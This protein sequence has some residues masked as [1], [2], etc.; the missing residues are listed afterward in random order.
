MIDSFLDGIT[1]AAFFGRLRR[2]G[3]PTAFADF[4]SER[5]SEVSNPL[6]TKTTLI[7]RRDTLVASNLRAQRLGQ[8]LARGSAAVLLCGT[9]Y[10]L[11]HAFLTM[12]GS[13][14]AP[15]PE[16]SG[17]LELAQALVFA[18]ALSAVVWSSSLFEKVISELTARASREQESHYDQEGKFSGSKS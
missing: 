6:D 8:W 7:G 9:I 16:L 12:S 3:S 15:A 18:I 10:E 4:R 17:I 13:T 5:A 11:V 1:G 14:Q 2:P